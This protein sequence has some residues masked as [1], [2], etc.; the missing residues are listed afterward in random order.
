VRHRY[1]HWMNEAVKEYTAT[2]KIKKPS[3]LLVANWVKESWDAIYINMVKRSFKCCGVSNAI[4]GSE[5]DL[6]FDSSRIEDVNN[7][8]RGIEEE[9]ENYNE[10]SDSNNEE[11]NSE[12]ESEDNYYEKNEE[13]NVI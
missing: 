4:D 10:D 1:N 9:N 7:H 5:D 12:Y 8:E 2:G 6:I 3:Y 13:Y 11:D